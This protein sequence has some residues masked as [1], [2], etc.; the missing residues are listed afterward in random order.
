[1]QH[2]EA[3]IFKELNDFKSKAYYMDC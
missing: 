2:A 1:M 3:L